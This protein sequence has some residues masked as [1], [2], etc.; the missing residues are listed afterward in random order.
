MTVDKEK[1]K[2]L[3]VIENTEIWI[4][5]ILLHQEAGIDT[6]EG[7]VAVGCVVRNRVKLGITNTKLQHQFGFNWL[8]VMTKPNQFSCFN[9]GINSLSL[10]GQLNSTVLRDCFQI[11]SKIYYNEL[12]DITFG[13][14]HYYNHLLCNPEWAE[15]ALTSRIIGKHTFCRLTAV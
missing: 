9:K 12:T 11:A 2:L 5:S 14:D 1:S 4:L 13:A 6:Y 3:K 10:T 15:Y 7:K 8:G